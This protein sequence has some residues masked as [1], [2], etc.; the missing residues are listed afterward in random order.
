MPEVKGFDITLAIFVGD[1]VLQVD[2]L[3]NALKDFS[4]YLLQKY[5]FRHSNGILKKF[6][7]AGH[8]CLP[9]MKSPWSCR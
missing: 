4:Y 5:A 3:Y 8:L 9:P 1:T 7:S 2:Q 6:V